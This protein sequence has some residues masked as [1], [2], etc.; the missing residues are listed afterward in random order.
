MR[1]LRDLSAAVLLTTTLAVEAAAEQVP[2][3]FR[4]ETI[5]TGTEEPERSRGLREA[6]GELLVKLTGNAGIRQDPALAPLLDRAGE[7]VES[8]ELEDRMRGIPVHDEQGTRERPHYLRV[9]FQAEAVE[10]ALAERGIELWGADRPLVAVWLAVRT[11]GEDYVL[12]AQGPK[13][14]GQRLAFE[15][16]ARRIGLPIAIAPL[17]AGETEPSPSESANFEAASLTGA[18]SGVTLFGT[19]DLRSGGYWDAEWLL[20]GS[21]ADERWTLQRTSFDT[22]I[23]EALARCALRL[24]RSAR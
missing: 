11:P 12:Q 24:S 20:H 6:F 8:I 14:Y 10:R 5:I 17:A 16:T 18:D 19:L 22:A 2:D 13:G 15:E 23:K 7:F 9:R 1:W 3:L 21:G 4:A